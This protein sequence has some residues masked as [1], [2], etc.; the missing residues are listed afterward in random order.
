M[1]PQKKQTHEAQWPPIVLVGDEKALFNEIEKNLSVLRDEFKNKFTGSNLGH[2]RNLIQ[3]NA[4]KCLELH[5]KLKHRGH[6]PV[7]SK[8]ML[9]NRRVSTSE[10]F[11]FYNHFHPQED[12][13]RFIQ[14]PGANTSTTNKIDTTLNEE[15]K[16][17]VYSQRFGHKDTYILT[18]NIDGWDLKFLSHCGQC[19]PDGD[20]YLYKNLEH[21][22]ISHPSSLP[23]YMESIWRRADQGASKDEVQKWLT[24]VAEWL[25]AC[26]KDKP[27]HILI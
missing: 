25:N 20:P 24:Q 1:Y 8:Y 10:S 23:S 27:E 6:S 15:F 12:L 4:H 13:I 9:R 26:E 14:N 21:D 17:C 3:Q 7:H 22:F 2:I 18:R 5:K 19:S 16:F 11:E